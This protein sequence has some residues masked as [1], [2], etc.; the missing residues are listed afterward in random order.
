MVSLLPL[1]NKYLQ[2]ITDFVPRNIIGKKK[3]KFVQTASNCWIYYM[4]NNLY[5]NTGIILDPVKVEQFIKNFGVNNLVWNP[6]LYWWLL[7]CEYIKLTTWKD[8]VV[9]QFS[10]LANP[11]LFAKLLM[12]WY[13]IGY[14]RD[15]WSK[16]LSDIQPDDELDTIFKRTSSSQH[17]TNIYFNNKKLTEL[18]S[19]WDNNIFNEFTYHDTDIFLKSVR[20]GGI[21]WMVQFL[22]YK[23]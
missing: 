1:K 23:K 20:A 4:L 19:R 9:N 11:Y 22:D 16:V 10:V 6:W 3:S 21:G 15:C 14:S 2:K 5:F 13:A 7:V 8:I 12:N 17:C 18:G